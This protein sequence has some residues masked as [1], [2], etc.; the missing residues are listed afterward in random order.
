VG[1]LPKPEE[2]KAI[3]EGIWHEE[4]HH[5]TAMEGNTMVLSQVKVLLEEGRAVGNKELT[6]YL[7]IRAY[8]DAAQW[9]YD[10]AIGIDDW[11]GRDLINLTELRQIHKLVVEPVWFRLLGTS[12]TRGPVHS[13]AM[14]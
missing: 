10:Q 7:E 14:M 6:E 9:V 11:S 8:A 12:R 5:S 13:G 4:T 1:G 2:A 3:W